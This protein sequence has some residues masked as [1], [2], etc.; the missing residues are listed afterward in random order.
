MRTSP[1][2]DGRALVFMHRDTTTWPRERMWRASAHVVV[3][4]A[5]RTPRGVPT[6]KT[7]RVPIGPAALRTVRPR[8]RVGSISSSAGI[9]TNEDIRRVGRGRDSNGELFTV[10]VVARSAGVSVSDATSALASF[11]EGELIF[12]GQIT[13]RD[14]SG[15]LVGPAYAYRYGRDDHAT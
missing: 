3:A 14:S 4:R 2:G 10:T 8:S 5:D 12:E 1:T 13:F 15:A 9:G 11:E 6:P 7:E